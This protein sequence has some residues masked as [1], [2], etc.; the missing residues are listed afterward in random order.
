MPHVY[1]IRCQRYFT[2]DIK[3]VRLGRGRSL[4]SGPVCRAGYC[5][6]ARKLLASPFLAFRRLSQGI[7]GNA[8]VITALIVLAS[9]RPVHASGPAVHPELWP[10]VRPALASDPAIES[11]LD[12]ILAGMTLE[13][14]V[15]Q[16][17]Q[18]DIAS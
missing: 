4:E 10:A 9:G 12:A 14:K 8:A 11:R 1:D 16:L 18:P 7:A 17:I 5:I 3:T 2:M 6:R 15:G 13:Q